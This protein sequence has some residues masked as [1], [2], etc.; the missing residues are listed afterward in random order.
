MDAKDRDKVARIHLRGC[1]D[2]AGCSLTLV[3]ERAA[4]PSHAL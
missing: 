2:D 1:G 4:K 3:E